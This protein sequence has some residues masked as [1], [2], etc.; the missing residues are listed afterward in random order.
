MILLAFSKFVIAQIAQGGVHGRTQ[1]ADEF[2]LSINV[3]VE[4]AEKI[5]FVAPLFA[6]DYL[7]QIY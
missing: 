2:L 6:A 3:D 1:V 4:I 7:C 5:T